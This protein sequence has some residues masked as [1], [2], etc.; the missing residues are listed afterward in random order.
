MLSKK[1]LDYLYPAVIHGL[2]IEIEHWRKTAHWDGETLMPVKVGKMCESLIKRGYLERINDRHYK[3]HATIRA[4][5][6]AL[7]LRCWKCH[8]GQI[9]DD[10]NEVIGDCPH[11][12]RGLIE[13]NADA[14]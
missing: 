2:K 11:C 4:T 12:Y 1:E 5:E 3:N 13:G 14:E 10:N 6:M 8:Q 9:Y 7:K